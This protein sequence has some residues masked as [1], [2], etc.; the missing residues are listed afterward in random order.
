MKLVFY[1]CFSILKEGEY[2]GKLV[3]EDYDNN[4]QSFTRQTHIRRLAFCLNVIYILMI[5]KSQKLFQEGN[6]SC[7]GGSASA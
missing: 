7:C 4:Y 2:G 5:P 6:G 3:N 1:D